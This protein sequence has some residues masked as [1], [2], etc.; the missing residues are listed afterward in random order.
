VFNKKLKHQLHKTETEVKDYQL[1][2]HSIKSS[3]A[4]IEFNPKAEIIDVNELFIHAVG[5]AKESLIGQHHSMFCKKAYAQS[6]EYRNFWLELN[7]GKAKSGVFERLDSQGNVLWLQATYFPV[8]DSQ[9]RVSK[10]VKIAS[11][12]TQ[13][14]NDLAAQRAIYK[15]LDRSNAIIEFTPKGQI[16]KA[17]Q[18][19]LAVMGYREQAI[20][21]KHHRM[22]CEDSFYQQYPK[23]WDELAKGEFKQGRFQRITASGETIWLEASYNP[24]YDAVGDVIKVV[25][26]ATDITQSMTLQMTIQQGAEEIYG[27]LGHIT[28]ITNKAKEHLNAAMTTSG[29]MAEQVRKTTL[30]TE[31]L[32]VESE[33]IFKIV[34]TINA[35]AEQTNLLALN[36]AIEAARAGETGRG[37]AVV[38][39]EVRNLA[40]R[41]SSST[42]E[43][44]SVVKQNRQMTEQVTKDIFSI[45]ETAQHGLIKIQDVVSIIDEVYKG[46]VEVSEAVSMMTGSKSK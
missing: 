7:Q 37:F 19:F 32:N 9:G 38:A 44:G 40:S 10:I 28:Q 45:S 23:F 35:I 36:A 34:S 46:A 6:S 42:A 33:N 30:L 11:D 4:Y 14:T 18:N 27:T 13:K 2:F 41:T 25:K 12:V 24:I 8:N 15:A 31:K 20:E 26:F 43:I 39:D 21:G 1:L 5:Y 17:N 3:V 22:F 16:I 29:Q